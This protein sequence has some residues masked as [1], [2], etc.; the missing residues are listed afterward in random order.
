MA[1]RHRRSAR[2][3]LL[4]LGR[5]GPYFSA[6]WEGAKGANAYS[7]SRHRFLSAWTGHDLSPSQVVDF[8]LFPW[9]T[10]D[11]KGD[12][13]IGDRALVEEYV[14]EPIASTGARWAFGFGKDWWDII[15]SLGLR[16]LDRLGD[17]G[18]PYPTQ[19]DHRRWLVAQG[20]GELRIAAM[21]LDSMPIPPTAG[22]TEDLRR[23]LENG[24]PGDNRQRNFPSE[25]ETDIGAR[26]RE[27]GISHTNIARLLQHVNDAELRIDAW[28]DDPA[29]GGV[30]LTVDGDTVVTVHREWADFTTSPAGS[31]AAESQRL[32]F[33][34][35]TVAATRSAKKERKPLGMCD[36]CYNVLNPDGTCPMECDQ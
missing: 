21:R 30:A 19:V 3:F 9:Q 27:L 29:D 36:Q 32:E 18:R 31:N 10:A 5:N 15:S 16:E 33:P 4:G 1:Y 7:A 13:F 25:L 26:L 2:R 11:W 6:R 28:H 12:A 23:V 24:P 20:P 35:V 22:E 17:G 34:T 8:S 14:L